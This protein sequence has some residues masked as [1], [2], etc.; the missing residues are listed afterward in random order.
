MDQSKL[1]SWQK[2]FFKQY[3]EKVKILI[4]PN[5][6]TNKQTNK[7]IMLFW[8]QLNLPIR[9]NYKMQIKRYDSYGAL[10]LSKQHTFF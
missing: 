10:Y 4:L 3:T 2:F 5:K 8:P 1:N 6:Q 9:I 7:R